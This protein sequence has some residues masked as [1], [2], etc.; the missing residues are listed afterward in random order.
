MLQTLLAYANGAG[1]ENRWLVL[2]GDAAFF[3]LTK[4]A[5][6]MLHGDPVTGVRSATRSTATTKASCAGTW[7]TSST[8]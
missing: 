5:H 1:I 8:S 6:N 7:P 4:R 3:S 2:S